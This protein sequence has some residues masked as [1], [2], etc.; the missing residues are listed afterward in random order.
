MIIRALTSSMP[1]VAGDSS[2]DHRTLAHAHDSA[3]CSVSDMDYTG[4]GMAILISS[5]PFA[6][7]D[8]S[9]DGVPV[10]QADIAQSQQYAAAACQI[11]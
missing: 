5:M 9:H 8:S 3:S 6:A 2:D 7:N 1:F 11:P 4:T 10:R